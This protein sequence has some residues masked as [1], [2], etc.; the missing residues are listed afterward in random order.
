MLGDSDVDNL[1]DFRYELYKHSPGEYV[2]VKFVRDG[3]EKT[4]KIN[5]GKS[6]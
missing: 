4:S 2:T 3:E 5:L 6:E 1:A